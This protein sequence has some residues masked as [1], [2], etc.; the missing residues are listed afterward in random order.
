MAGIEN[1]KDV[2]RDLAKFG[3]KV[4]D[5]LEDKKLSFAEAISL[6]V[7]A[8]P[9]AIEHAG[10]AADIKAEFLDLDT[11]EVDELV[12]YVS[13]ELDLANDK[14]EKVIECGFE[15][16]AATNDLRVAIKEAL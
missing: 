5:A 2:A 13:D 7:F 15:W 4:E 14:V 10:N 12:A 8:A 1:L 9:K 16:L 6:G 3:M 11:D